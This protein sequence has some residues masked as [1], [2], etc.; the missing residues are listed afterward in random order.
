MKKQFL[1]LVIMALGF[2]FQANAIKKQLH[3]KS[4]ISKAVKVKRAKEN[5]KFTQDVLDGLKKTTG[6]KDVN[7]IARAEK[8]LKRA[9]SHLTKI[10]SGKEIARKAHSLTKIGA[11]KNTSIDVK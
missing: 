4:P 11:P 5:L 6:G 2:G 9:K 8:M 10:E 1:L 3:G 7:F